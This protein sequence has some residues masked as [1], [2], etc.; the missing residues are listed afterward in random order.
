MSDLL[1][2]ELDAVL[3]RLRSEHDVLPFMQE[4]FLPPARGSRHFPTR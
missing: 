4:I 3:R 1:A 2:A